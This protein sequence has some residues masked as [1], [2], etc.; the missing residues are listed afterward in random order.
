MTTRRT[1]SAQKEPRSPILRNETGSILGVNIAP[2]TASWCYRGGETS[3]SVQ[4]GQTLDI[5]PNTL[6]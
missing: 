2:N 4:A 6:P 3:L 1:S 5:A